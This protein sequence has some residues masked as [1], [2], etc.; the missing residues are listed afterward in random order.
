MIIKNENDKVIW[1]N[2]TFGDVLQY[3]FYTK[4]PP[5]IV[6]IAWRTRIE[7]PQDFILG[8]TSFRGTCR[9]INDIQML[10]MNTTQLIIS[11]PNCFMHVQ[12]TELVKDY[13]GNTVWKLYRQI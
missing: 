3:A 9:E 4:T 7:N 8:N 1:L 6:Q 13:Y 12:P 2:T 5:S 11:P 10:L